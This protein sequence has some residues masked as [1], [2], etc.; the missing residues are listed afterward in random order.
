MTYETKKMSDHELLEWLKNCTPTR[1]LSIIRDSDELATK[2][3]AA[4]QFMLSKGIIN[5]FK[6]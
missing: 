2:Y 4:R 6:I 5:E 1:I 3:K